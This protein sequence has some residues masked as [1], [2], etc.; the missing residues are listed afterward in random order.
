MT[1][2]DLMLLNWKFPSCN[3]NTR[4]TIIW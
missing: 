2:E 3:D 1:P 4:G